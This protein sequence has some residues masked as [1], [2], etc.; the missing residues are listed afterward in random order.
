[1]LVTPN[2]TVN[3]TAAS[4]STAAVTQSEP[5]GVRDIPAGSLPGGGPCR[6]R[7]DARAPVRRGPGACAYLRRGARSAAVIK[8]N[9]GVLPFG[10]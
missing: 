9:E 4:A 8:P 2:W 6:R 7:P 5:D 10:W 1:M 3:P